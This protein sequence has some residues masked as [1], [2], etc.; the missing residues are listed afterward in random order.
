MGKQIERDYW[1]MCAD[2]AQTKTDWVCA[3]N[4]LLGRPC[5]QVG[6]Q[7]I[8]KQKVVR[9]PLIIVPIPSPFCNEKWNYNDHGRNWNCKCAE[10]YEQSPIDLPN[11]LDATNI[12]NNIN[13]DYKMVDNPKIVLEENMLT[14]K[15]DWGYMLHDEITKGL[16]GLQRE[17][18]I[19]YKATEVVFK[20]P[21]DHTIQGK[22]YPLEV[23]I[24]H[25]ATSQGD[26]RYNAVVS[27][28]FE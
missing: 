28:L 13:F 3:I 15:G 2:D 17:N 25:K 9:Q 20:T 16:Y 26:L 8:K 21:S 5:G 23:Q 4:T 10:G 1:T 6:P 18:I 19:N 14:I 12:M 24:I 27:F 7:I 22:Q 11:P